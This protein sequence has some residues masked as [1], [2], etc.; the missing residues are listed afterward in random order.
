MLLPQLLKVDV[1]ALDLAGSCLDSAVALCFGPSPPSHLLVSM[2]SNMITVL[3]AR[4]GRVVRQVS[5]GHGWRPGPSPPGPGL[6]APGA[7]AGRPW[8]ACC[9]PV[10]ARWGGLPRPAV[11][12][13]PTL[14][15][16]KC[17]LLQL[18]CGHPAAC[19]SLSLSADG[20]FLLTAAE[21]AVRLWDYATQAGLSCQVCVPG[22]WA[23]GWRTALGAPG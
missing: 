12:G 3:D 9:S 7:R 23:G 22:G 19:A 4:S 21:R 6:A 17:T 10:A 13:A 11:L 20:R 5:P 1:S 8:A 15:R 14:P 18:S 16:S 2:S